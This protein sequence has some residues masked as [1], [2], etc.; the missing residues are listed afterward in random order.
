MN[1]TVL[2]SKT[3]TPAGYWDRYGTG[4]AEEESHE[5]AL[6]NAFG[7]CQYDGHGPG[8]ELLG[9]PTTALELGFG[10]GNAVAALALQGISATGVDVSGVQHENAAQR[11]RHVP[12]A[13]FVCA[14]ALDY[15]SNTTRRWDAIYSIWGAAWFTDPAL[16]LP[17]GFDHLEPGGRLA[18]SSAPPVPGAYGPQGMYGAGFR[19]RPVWLYRWSYEPDDWTDILTRHGFTGVDA[20]IHPAPNPDLLGT[21]IVAARRPLE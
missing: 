8:D 15:L 20:R 14:E 12:G 16:L 7:W 9:R 1:H 10:R 11:W 21:L 13:E 17:L 3:T 19:G 5:E 6:K 2:P 4:L 18:F